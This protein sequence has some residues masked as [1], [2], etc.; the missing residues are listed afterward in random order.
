MRTLFA[1]I[2]PG[3][4]SYARPWCPRA[5]T[6]GVRRH[7]PEIPITTSALA[8]RGDRRLLSQG[9]TAR[10]SNWSRGSS[11]TARS[12][13]GGLERRVFPDEPARVLPGVRR[14]RCRRWTTS[15]APTA[16]P[17]WTS[18][19][20]RTARERPTMMLSR[21]RSA[22]PRMRSTRPGRRPT[23][24]R[25]WRLSVLSRTDRPGPLGLDEFGSGR[26]DLASD[27][28]PGIKPRRWVRVR[29]QTREAPVS[30]RRGPR[31]S[32]T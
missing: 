28:G 6:R 25:P 21:P 9:S 31:R 3:D 17:I 10:T 20:R 16:R 11:Q 30:R 24:A 23:E 13:R 27:A 14:V 1:L 4:L 7:H 29:A 12:C 32:S 2:A 5:D 26:V 8:E 18:W 15:C 22:S 19:S